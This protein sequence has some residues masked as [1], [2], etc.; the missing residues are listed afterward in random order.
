MM[1]IRVLQPHRRPGTTLR[2]ML[3]VAAAIAVL[4]LSQGSVAAGAGG[5]VTGSVV[6]PLPTVTGPL[7]VTAMSYPWGAAAHGLTPID[8]SAHRYVEQEFLVGGTANVYSEAGSDLTYSA[9]GPYQTRL[10]I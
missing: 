4:F 6:A 8:L 7:G 2:P 3:T 9:S 1:R 5:T 10:L